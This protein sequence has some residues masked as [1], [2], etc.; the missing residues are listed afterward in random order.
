M[1]KK[2]LV[3]INPASGQPVP[4]LNTLNDVFHQAGVDWDIAITQERGDAIRFAREAAAAGMDMVAA[5][6]GDGTVMEVAEGL[7]G[8]NV[9]LAIL[10]GGTANL[11][12]RELSIPLTLRE[13]AELMI[14]EDTPLYDI[15]MGRVS[16]DF[17][18]QLFMLRVGVGQEANKVELADRQL[19][20][21]YGMMAY[22][23]AAI[24]S[25]K[26]SDKAT[27][28]LTI[29]GRSAEVV[30]FTCLVDNA[31]N[32]GFRDI[33]FAQAIDVHDGFMDLIVIQ[34]LGFRSVYSIAAS[35]ADLNP[36]KNT[37]HHW[38]ARHLTIDT[39]P[40][41][42]VHADGEVIGHTPITISVL[43]QKLPVLSPLAT[44]ELLTPE[45]TKIDLGRARQT[46]AEHRLIII[47][48]PNRPIADKALARIK[49][50]N[51]EEAINLAD[52][53]LVE[54]TAR[55]KLKIEPL[56]SL[57]AKKGL[58]RGLGAGLVLGVLAATPALGLV[59][60]GGAVGAVWGKLG[61]RKLENRLKQELGDVLTP[62][63]AA[64]CSI[65]LEA[66]W[67]TARDR[68]RQWGGELVSAELTQEEYE[69]L[70]HI[71]QEEDVAT[72][73][74]EDSD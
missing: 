41:Q 20:D 22:S 36:N 52:A 2:I 10:P 68:S 18:E 14:Q 5:Y 72:A 47:K 23:V 19:K 53:V 61:G 13:A 59:L 11:M 31:G 34:D 39:T 3:I 70:T 21:K 42:L 73:V 66:D 9:P 4:I 35:V 1:T 26:E 32:I 60:A 40:P 15:D 56:A 24:Q 48:Y 16:G 25:L 50:L 44:G 63:E 46:D 29:D 45:P 54:K 71:A 38:Q 43:P 12:A 33:S 69:M 74:T 55:G 37:F 27:Y 28:Q 51:H 6:G 57:S 49:Q 8:A 58:K 65:I 7:Q 64:I 62:G 17:G 67:Q 30:G